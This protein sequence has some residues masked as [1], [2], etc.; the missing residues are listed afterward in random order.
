MQTVEA[1]IDYNTLYDRYQQSLL[2]IQSL[3]HELQQLKKMIFG[4][5]HERF[6]PSV[7]NPYS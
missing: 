7:Q 4:S 1:H 3:E 5:K 2:T 6:V